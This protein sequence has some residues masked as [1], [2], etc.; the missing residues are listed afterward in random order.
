MD[1]FGRILSLK[2][3]EPNGPTENGRDEGETSVGLA[4]RAH[5]QYRDATAL[6]FHG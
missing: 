1:T 6:F 2:V 3:T 5:Y 4:V